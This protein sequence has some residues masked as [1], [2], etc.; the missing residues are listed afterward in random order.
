MPQVGAKADM[1]MGEFWVGGG[2]SDSVKLAAS[3]AHTH[4]IRIVGA[5]SFTADP[6]QGKWLNHPGALKA[7]GDLQWCSGINRSI[8][9]CYAHQPWTNRYPA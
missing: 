7:L 6:N 9:H 2:E 1:L 4:G 3:V 5:K 8:F